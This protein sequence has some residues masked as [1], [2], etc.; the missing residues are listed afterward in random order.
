M[1]F[2]IPE[3][4]LVLLGSRGQHLVLGKPRHLSWECL[5]VRQFRTAQCQR[6]WDEFWIPQMRIPADTLTL[7]RDTW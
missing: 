1:S 6:L 7:A 2:V 4:R 3:E 5:A